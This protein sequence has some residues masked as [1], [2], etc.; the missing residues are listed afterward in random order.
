MAKARLSVPG[1]AATADVL[2]VLRYNPDCMFAVARKSKFN[3]G[4]A[5]R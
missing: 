3:P 1:L 5:G 2:K 4:C